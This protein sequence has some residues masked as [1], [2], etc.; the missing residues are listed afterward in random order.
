MGVPLYMIL[1]FYG[2]SFNSFSLAFVNFIMIYL[3]VGHFRFL[4]FGALFASWIWILFPSPGWGSVQSLFCQIHFL[5]VLCP[6][7]FWDPYNINIIALDA[8]SSVSGSVLLFK[9]L[10]FLLAGLFSLFF[11]P[12]TYA[13]SSVT[14]A[15][16]GSPRGTFH[17]S[18]VLFSSGL[19]YFV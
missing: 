17:F 12:V 5:L 3:G 7:S 8:A 16:A 18:V 1:G 2:A 6:L 13:F 15:A 14:Q 11:L 4:L 9:L 19:F 10:L